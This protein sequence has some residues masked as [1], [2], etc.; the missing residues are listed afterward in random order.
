MVKQFTTY[1]LGTFIGY[2]K[3]F[4]AK[5]ESNLTMEDLK[6]LEEINKKHMFCTKITNPTY[7]EFV[8]DCMAR[9]AK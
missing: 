1:Q 4:G 7:V 9:F 3:T 2:L 6:K 8:D 5:N